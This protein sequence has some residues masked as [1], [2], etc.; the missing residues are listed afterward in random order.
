[1]VLYMFAS[2]FIVQVRDQISFS[3]WRLT[4][5][6]KFFFTLQLST[7]VLYLCFH[8]ISRR[9]R[10]KRI[11]HFLCPPLS[12][13]GRSRER[14]MTHHF[15]YLPYPDLFAFAMAD[16]AEEMENTAEF[17][18]RALKRIML[19]EIMNI[20]ILL[21]CNSSVSLTSFQSSRRDRKKRGK[22]RNMWRRLFNWHTTISD[23][24]RE[25]YAINIHPSND[26][27]RIVISSMKNLA[28]PSVY[29]L[30]S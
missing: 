28:L 17:G 6:F 16:L 18:V 10:A 8:I 7:C 26:W 19:G 29:D 30:T 22:R 3:S 4:S 23:Q 14:M 20:T 12:S 27:M 13:S 2:W 11:V 15:A 9:V 1:M 21:S 5:S 24:W 25:N